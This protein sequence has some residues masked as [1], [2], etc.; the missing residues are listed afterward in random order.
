MNNQTKTLH[1]LAALIA[2]GLTL[3]A[4][5]AMAAPPKG[6]VNINQAESSQLE[7]LPRIGPALAGRILEMRE[8]DGPF[9]TVEDLMLVRGIG[10]KTFEMLK[11]FLVLTGETTLT[12]KVRASEVAS[13]DSRR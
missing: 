12:E 13:D 10:E 7:L 8:Q 11:P 9:K 6:V 5:P 4:G 3:L 2:L 1:A